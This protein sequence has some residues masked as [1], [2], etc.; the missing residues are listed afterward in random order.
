MDKF[1]KEQRIYEEAIAFLQLP[2]AEMSTKKHLQKNSAKSHHRSFRLSRNRVKKE[3]NAL[4][5]EE[6]ALGG[7]RWGTKEEEK[8]DKVRYASLVGEYGKLLAHLKRVHLVAQSIG[9]NLGSADAGDLPADTY[10]DVP[11]GLFNKTYLLENF[12]Q[13]LYA[14][15]NE[16]SILSI[17]LISLDQFN[18]LEKEYLRPIAESLK[19]CL[20]RGSDFISHLGDG[21]FIAVLPHTKKT[22]V[23][24]VASRMQGLVYHISKGTTTASVAA[25]TGMSQRTYWTV[26]DFLTC[27]ENCLAQ[28]KAQGGNHL[29]YQ[30]LKFK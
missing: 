21:K 15:K 13:L 27:A 11:T 30:G 10:F 22:G 2:Y 1:A 20:Y 26:Q 19:S 12:E 9:Y 6:Y 18:N 24:L 8:V 16:N 23:R 7:K 28:A 14:L 5:G 25:V 29:V 3:N 17:A 4:I